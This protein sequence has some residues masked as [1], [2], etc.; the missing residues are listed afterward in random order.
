MK[1]GELKQE[2]NYDPQNAAVPF[3]CLKTH[4]DKTTSISNECE[5]MVG[6]CSVTS[7][8]DVDMSRII[9]D[10]E[11]DSVL[12]S[13]LST[14]RDRP[15]DCD[16]CQAEFISHAELESHLL[17]HV[18]SERF[19]CY[20]CQ[21]EFSQSVSLKTHM[22][23]HSGTRPHICDICQKGFTHRRHLKVHMVTHTGTKA[24]ACDVCQMPF[25]LLAN[26]KRH[27]LTHMGNKP[28]VCN[29]C[30]TGFT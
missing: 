27:R 16:V 2:Q 13:Q 25:S 9:V 20:I 28:Y 19:V 29:V 10:K 15:L 8:T 11:D 6:L 12:S 24:H 23:S 14:Q 18:D 21:Q 17:T 1:P 4:A 5:E 30:K 26:M 3:M 22:L 7:S